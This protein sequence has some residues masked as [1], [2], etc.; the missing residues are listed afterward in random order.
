MVNPA[1]SVG[2]RVGD[3]LAGKHR[4]DRIIGA[5]GMGIVVAA[6]NLEPDERVA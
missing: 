2:V 4:V 3:V 6:H 1:K 5:G